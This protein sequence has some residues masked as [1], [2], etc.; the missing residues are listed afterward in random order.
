M[1][2]QVYGAVTMNN[3]M[4]LGLFL[5]VV[6]HR[7]LAWTF[8]SET[9]PTTAQ[10]MPQTNASTNSRIL[11]MSGRPL[12]RRCSASCR[13]IGACSIAF[14][15][16]QPANPPAAGS[17][18]ICLDP[19]MLVLEWQVTTMFSVFAL[20]AVAASRDTFPT[21]YAL[22]SLALYP[23]ALALVTCLDY[24]VGWQ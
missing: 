7:S 10:A 15:F 5:M 20:G 22:L 21:Y 12:Q 16:A 17:K 6:A 24:V 4:C 1:N 18:L 13:R 3:T 8:S 19:L 23:A 11:C 9:V 2:I 14:V